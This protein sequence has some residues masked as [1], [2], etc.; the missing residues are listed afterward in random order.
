M[1]REENILELERMFEN[2]PE[3]LSPVEVSHRI[4]FEKNEYMN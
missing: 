2:C 3:M 1:T 4:P